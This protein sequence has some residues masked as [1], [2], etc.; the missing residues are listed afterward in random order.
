MCSYKNYK[1][2]PTT[3]YST[4]I[5]FLFSAIVITCGLLVNNRFRNKLKEE[6][7]NRLPGRKGNVIEPIMRW[8]LIL[9]MVFWPYQMIFFWV[10]GHEILPSEWFKNCWLLNLIARPT[11]FGTII[12]YNSFFVAL[13]RYIYIVHRRQANKW[14][15][16]KIG[17]IL[18]LASFVIPIAMNT[19]IMLTQLGAP[20]LRTNNSLKHVLLQ[21]KASILPL[22]Y[23]FLPHFPLNLQ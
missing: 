4:V 12:Y 15:F 7:R 3:I 8:H 14:D 9:S 11:T 19:I 18:R 22:I 10:M 5:D 20:G 13:I 6:K 21:M 23:K 17:K 1:S 2:G 16:E